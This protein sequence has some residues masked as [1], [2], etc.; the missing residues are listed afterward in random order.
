MALHAKAI[1]RHRDFLHPFEGQRILD[2]DL[3]NHPVGGLDKMGLIV[4]AVGRIQI[5]FVLGFFRRS[6]QSPRS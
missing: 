4:E 2:A 1:R 5:P 6:A 3:D